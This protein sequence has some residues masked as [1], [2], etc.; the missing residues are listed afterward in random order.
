MER[1]SQQISAA[2]SEGSET[3][4]T[5]ARLLKERRDKIIT[6]AADEVSEKRISEL[7][8]SADGLRE[9]AD[10]KPAHSPDRKLALAELE[11]VLV[12]QRD[13]IDS[14]L[15]RDRET[16]TAEL[17]N[18]VRKLEILAASGGI[19]AAERVRIGEEIA[20]GK[21]ELGSLAESPAAG[22]GN[23]GGVDSARVAAVA[24]KDAE[25]AVNAAA[26]KAAA[27]VA[28]ANQAI[29]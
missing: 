21:I 1:L 20:R 4:A 27:D 10:K 29:A 19:D 7:S 2:E 9:F 23:S 14:V 5:K 11:N 18:E 28:S 16:R 13:E 22:N 3:G 6:D 25:T 8:K 15:A 17:R 26:A 24:S 12:G